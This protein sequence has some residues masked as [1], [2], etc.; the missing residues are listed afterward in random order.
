[1]KAELRGSLCPKERVRQKVIWEVC[2]HEAAHAVVA[3]VLG[4]KVE[5]LKVDRFGSYSGEC[6]VEFDIDPVNK[7]HFRSLMAYI[8]AGF[9]AQHKIARCPESIARDCSGGDRGIAYNY[10]REYI[11]DDE[12][13]ETA[14]RVAARL[15]RRHRRLIMRVA[16]AL[17][18]G[19][20]VYEVNGILQR[21]RGTMA[22]EPATRWLQT[23]TD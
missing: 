5:R 1:M 16:K 13:E 19:K 9:W 10:R 6:Y 18:A 17:R 22:P 4:A 2:V 8:H 23:G 20:D 12:V 14:Y 7:Q 21:A 15:V 3:F 11:I